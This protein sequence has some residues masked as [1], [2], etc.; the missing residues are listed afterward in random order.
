MIRNGEIYEELECVL[1]QQSTSPQS[2][3]A[4]GR[5]VFSRKE[6]QRC[7]EQT[8]SWRGSRALLGFS[9]IC[10]YHSI[11]FWAWCI[12]SLIPLPM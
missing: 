3:N 4:N 5:K 9:G 8:P 11:L 12:L 7:K 1:Q 2:T 10:F 6:W